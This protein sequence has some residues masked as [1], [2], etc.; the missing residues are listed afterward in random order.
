[1]D[2]FTATHKIKDREE[3]R[4]SN[5]VL[6]RLR[7]GVLA[8]NA[9]E[10]ARALG[11]TVTRA[12]DDGESANATDEDGLDVWICNHDEA[13][14]RWDRWRAAHPQPTTKE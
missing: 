6:E 8:N 11:L 1:M 3:G 10:A 2:R 4:V 12:T 7:D 9:T 14:E 5:A 13:V